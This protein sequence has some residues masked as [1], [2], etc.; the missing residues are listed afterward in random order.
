MVPGSVERAAEAL[1]SAAVNWEEPPFGLSA[2]ERHLVVFEN[3]SRAF[4]KGA[5][6]AQTADWLRTEHQLLGQVGG[7]FGPEVVA[8]IDDA[9]RPVMVTS[10]LSPAYWPAAS[11]TTIWR[12]RDI[13]AVLGTLQDLAAAPVSRE[14]PSVAWPQPC[15]SRLV[16]R[17]VPARLGL[18]STDWID[19]HGPLLVDLDERAAPTGSAIVHGD[20]RSD[21]L[22]LLPDGHVRLVDWSHGG[23]GDPRHD[24]VTL[25][26]SLQLEGGPA[27]SARLRD[28]IEMI[29][30]FAGP[31]IARAASRR[32]IPDWLR[33]VLG[34]LASIQLTWIAEILELPLDPSHPTEPNSR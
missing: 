25:V 6:D 14:L 20:V 17:R 8:W 26:P 7:R 4:V 18:C 32:A 9:H 28:P 21:N 30:R 29:V 15:W 12:P 33:D 23:I 19:R 31:T 2:A 16:E 11:G 22:C 13:D 27:P 10:D 5:T 1:R 34:R 24:L 3:G